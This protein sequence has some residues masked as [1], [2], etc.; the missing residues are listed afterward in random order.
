MT[1]T[2][3]DY[4]YIILITGYY[5]IIDNGIN[6]PTI[7]DRPI[8]DRTINDRTINDHANEENTLMVNSSDVVHL[9]IDYNDNRLDKISIRIAKIIKNSDR[10]D[11]LDQSS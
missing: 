6:D 1:I 7:N 5:I 8:N 11:L 4:I 10:L 2:I 9:N 3:N